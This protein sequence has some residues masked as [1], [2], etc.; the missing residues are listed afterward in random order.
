MSKAAIVKLLEEHG[1]KATV[2]RLLVAEAL[3][4]SGRPLSMTEL[5]T[6]IESVD[7]SGIFRS[8]MTFKD[9]HLVH[10]IEDM[11][12]T[13][14]EL[15]HSHDTDHDDDAHVHFYCER[16]HRTF[17]LDNIHIPAVELPAG[18]AP[19]TANYVIKGICPSCS[20]TSIA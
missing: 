19:K 13:R 10:A 18:Y 8:L 3:S 2:N 1:V 15:C 4:R 20:G 14:Y 12:G 5:E 6:E 11:E 9:H 17:C 16:C 7:K